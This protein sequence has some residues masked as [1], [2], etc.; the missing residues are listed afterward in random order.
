MDAKVLGGRPQAAIDGRHDSLVIKMC[1]RLQLILQPTWGA[2]TR[3][4]LMSRRFKALSS[5]VS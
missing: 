2:R 5:A 1:K 3:R 4:V